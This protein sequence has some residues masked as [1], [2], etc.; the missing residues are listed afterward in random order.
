MANIV[1]AIGLTGCSTTLGDEG[2]YAMDQIPPRGLNIN[3]S[4][5]R[6]QGR[7][8]GA[9]G[10]RNMRAYHGQSNIYRGDLQD[11]YFDEEDFPEEDCASRKEGGKCSCAGSEIGCTTSLTHHHIGNGQSP[12]GIGYMSTVQAGTA[13]GSEEHI[14]RKPGEEDL[15][16]GSAISGEE[17]KMADGITKT[18]EVEI[19][20]QRRSSKRRGGGEQ[21]KGTRHGGGGAGGGADTPSPHRGG[22][23]E[24]A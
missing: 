6:S 20:I 14:I 16:R 5:E 15:E 10:R 3:H 1:K 11:D 17:P 9:S 7:G 12:G 8:K 4:H 21:W 22:D 23:A 19:N 18:T 24:G 2:E 13:H